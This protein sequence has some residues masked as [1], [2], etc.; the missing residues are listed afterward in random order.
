M[1]FVRA[2]NNHEEQN[3]VAYQFNDD[4]YFATCKVSLKD[5]QFSYFEGENIIER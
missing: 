4:I 2:A 1:M 5:T 3:L